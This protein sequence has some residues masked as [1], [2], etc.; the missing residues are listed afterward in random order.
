[1]CSQG[2][3]LI[4]SCLFHIVCP[5]N[6]NVWQK[7]GFLGFSLKNKKIRPFGLV[8]L[9]TLKNVWDYLQCPVV[10]NI[11]WDT[12]HIKSKLLC[13]VK[14]FHF[15]TCISMYFC[16]LFLPSLYLHRGWTNIV[17]RFSSC[18]IFILDNLICNQ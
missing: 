6:E 11:C 13:F 8:C 9:L 15:K 5:V 10:E 12:L 7:S 16:F 3:P 18:G 4:F 17:A 1:M 14:I 2:V